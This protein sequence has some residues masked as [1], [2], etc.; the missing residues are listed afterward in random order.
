MVRREIRLLACVI[1]LLPCVAAAQQ[2]ALIPVTETA[3]SNGAFVRGMSNDGKRILFES[4]NDYTG[5]NR[6]GNNEIF[7]YDADSRKVIQLTQTGGQSNGGSGGGGQIPQG[8]NCPGGCP[9]R[10]SSSINAVPAISGDGAHIVFASTSSLLSDQPNA[11]GNAEIYLATLPRGATAATFIRITET[12]GAKDSFDNNT[13]AINFDGSV[14]AFVSTRS[15]FKSRGV[16]IF[17]AQNPDTNAQIYTYDVSRRRYIQV[18]AKRIDEGTDQFDVKGFISN[19]FLSGDGAWL[20]FLSGY[21]FSGAARPNNADLNGE[22]FLYRVG[23]PTNQVRQVTDTAETAQTPEDG[24]VNVLSR[25]GKH[26]SDDGSRLVFESAGGAAPVREGAKVRDVFLYNRSTNTFAQITAQDAGKPDLSD[27][28]Y[29][30]SLNGAGTFVTFSSKLNL[31]VVNDTAGNFNNSREA[32]R[33]D[34]AAAQ[35]SLVTQT[36]IAREPADQRRVLFAPW[37][38]DDGQRIG[39]SNNGNLIAPKFNSTPEVFL[40]VLRPIERESGRA[41][42]AVNAA[43]F[44]S[45]RI[46]RG[47]LVLASGAAL[48]AEAAQSAEFDNYP[49]ELNGVS[50]TAGESL[51]GIAARMISVGPEQ[52]QF[53]F[54]AGLNPDAETELPFVINYNGVLSRGQARVSDAAPGVFTLRGDGRGQADGRCFARSADGKENRY[55]ALPCHIGYDRTFDTLVLYGTGWRFGR[56]IKVRLRF[57]NKNGENDE[58]EVTPAYA[59]RYVDE[60]GRE[61]LGQDEIRIPL[62]KVLINL[63]EVE[64]TILL[65]SSAESLE[66]QAGVTTDFAGFEEDMRIING[67]TQS[68]G[69]IARGSIAWVLTDNDDEDDDAA[70][71]PDVFSEQTMVAPPDAPALELGGVRVEVAGVRARIL[72][73]APDEV[74][75]VTPESIEA[76]ENVLVRVTTPHEVF[77][78]RATIADV[79]PGLFTRQD[80]GKGPVDGRC[81]A[82]QPDGAIRYTPPPCEVGAADDQR[83]LVLQGTGWRFATGIQARFDNVDLI[84]TFAGAEPGLPGV[85]RIEIPINEELAGRENEIVLTVSF[86]GARVSSQPGATI[87]FGARTS[88]S[89]SARDVGARIRIFARMIRAR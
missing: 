69:P 3:A 61:H 19:P 64:T 42:Q 66:S 7:V 13:P 83:I 34:V 31:P 43:S 51:G 10:A 52:V 5:E 48:P 21:N 20:A 49:F 60:D 79:A 11:D 46:A 17:S 28:N 67:A 36:E 75:F 4:A 18:T 23:D 33:Y 15:L 1:W 59:G 41:V 81:G 22:I 39:F 38:S 77:N 80:D 29:F 27:F 56:G 68:A 8:R 57:V 89:V 37:I 9:P 74:R 35:L 62:D 71:P 78:V 86:D 45:A 30:P 40:A 76:A 6:D 44:D 24:A 82:I 26:L 85:D 88:V 50:V 54:P 87:A 12:D 72:R 53:V 25:F 32:Y 84:P 55:T 2:I 16:L 65:D 73:V 58:R 47:S 14:I 63:R 70:E